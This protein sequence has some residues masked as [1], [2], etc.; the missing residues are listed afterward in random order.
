MTQALNSEGVNAGTATSIFGPKR[1]KGLKEDDIVKKLQ[2]SDYS[3]V[4]S[5]SL[6]K[7]ERQRNYVPSTYYA[8]P[9]P[10]NH[11]FYRR[12]WYV[13]DRVYTPGYYTAS[14]NWVLEADIYTIDEDE[15]I[16]S[17]QTRSYDPDNA[18]HLL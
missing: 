2:N 10:G 9:Y 5:V 1:L 11:S 13:Y 7:K 17:S 4:M 15:L 12:Y 16:Y 3:A 18:K 6:V 14:T 8:Y